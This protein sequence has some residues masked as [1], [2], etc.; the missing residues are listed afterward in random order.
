MKGRMIWRDIVR[1]KAVSLAIVLFI[2]ASA[3]LMSLALSLGVNLLGAIDRLMQVAETPHFM[4]MHSGELDMSKLEAFAEE[5]DCVSDFQ[6]LK[7]LNMDSSQ[8][9]IGANSL[10]DNLQDNGF[11]TQSERFD[12]LLDLDNE[13]VRPKDGELYVPVCYLRDGTARIGDRA[14]INGRPFHVAGFVRDSQMNSMLASS[15]RFV[16][17]E[18][19]YASLEPLGTTEYLIEFRLH[20]LSKLGAFET[21]YSVAGLPASGPTLTWPLFR[22]MSAASDG[23]M[24]AV[25]VLTSVLVTL[26]AMFCIR[27]TLLAK[28]EDDYREIG[29]M[30]AIGMRT[31]DIKGV[32]LTSYTVLAAFGSVLGFLLSLLLQ[33]PMKESVRMN[34]GDVGGNTLGLMLGVAGVILVFS[35]VLFYVNGVLRRFHRISAVQAIRF[36]A[37]EEAVSGV[38]RLR[39]SENRLISTNLF[40]GVKDV[41]SRK[42]LYFTMLVVI[43]LASF[44]MIL[45]QNLYHTISDDDFVSYMGVGRC[46]IRLDIQ[47]TEGI[48][49]KTAEIERHMALDR[50]IEKYALFT[51]K[52][53]RT[54]LEDGTVEN[55]KVELGDHAVFP[56]QY[57]KGRMPMSENEIALSAINAEELGKD[58][59]DRITLLTDYKEIPLTVCGVYSDITNGGKTSKAVFS[60]DSTE[61][62]WSVI[63]ADLKDLG[64]LDDKI[65]EYGTR[66]SYAKVSSIDEYVAQTFG[67]TLRSVR[68]AALT[69]AVV[70]VAITLLVT[71]LFMKL[72][73]T[74]DR[75]SIAVMR[76]LGFT[77]SDVARQYM[78]R[79][80]FVLA[81]GVA[82]GTLMAGT[83]G[84]R[85]AGMVISSFGATTFHF[86]VNSLF[87]YFLSPLIMLFAALIATSLATFEAG[88]V[89]IYESIKE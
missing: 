12:F 19:D 50:G 70:A 24:I 32:Y 65:Y 20:D 53:F 78:C 33:G 26:I 17:S 39:L 51:T 18:G 10:V 71:L 31:S 36:G 40:L 82:I 69:A 45:P 29:V 54:R 42:R 6:T 83:F 56:L 85:L 77:N 49:S 87:T 79:S 38:K 23:I 68:I 74:K 66:F 13:V 84:E 4:Q 61:T 67:Q 11:C 47:Q 88:T 8:I 16:V 75:H 37:G 34:L 60:D 44:I 64:Q 80:V 52:A 43:V 62:A 14:V 1:N 73:V 46:D 9:V 48:D 89:H 55:V 58:V 22:M 5:N 30:K 76:S 21:A 63:C 41:L 81:I 86:T 57:A 7:F 15:K 72:M 3:M 35:F 28:I 59:G 25:I 27:F 2:A